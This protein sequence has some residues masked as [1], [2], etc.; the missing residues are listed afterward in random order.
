[1]NCNFE[2]R[3][4]FIEKYLRKELNESDQILFEKHFVGCDKCYSEVA[5]TQHLI[6]LIQDE[7]NILFPEHNNK[8][9]EPIVTQ[10]KVSALMHKIFP[11]KWYLKPFP[12]FT[13]VAAAVII[14]GIYFLNSSVEEKNETGGNEQIT[15]KDNEIAPQEDE[16]PV[17]PDQTGI[18]SE[19]QHFELYAANFIE[20]DNLESMIDLQFRGSGNI[21][22]ISPELGVIVTNEIL[23]NWD[24]KSEQQLHLIILNN[25]EDI[26]FK[27]TPNKSEFSF[28]IIEKELNPGLYYWKL[29]SD[30][31]L[32]H[33][34][35]FLIKE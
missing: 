33:V 10:F 8:T 1:M 24:S 11:P 9:E 4:V 3:E 18:E 26:L 35:K 25:D 27:F 30:A 21:N 32:F 16:I 6:D 34:G 13:F 5:S 7:G 2:N 23:F 31:D 28:N 12:A 20:S 15:I 17:N 14:L 29:E 19:N 22:V